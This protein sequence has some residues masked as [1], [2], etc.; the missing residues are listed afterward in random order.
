[1]EEI[2]SPEIEKEIGKVMKKR[3]KGKTIRLRLRDIKPYPKNSKIHTEKQIIKLMNS[4]ITFGYKAKIQVD[5]N[6]VVLVGHGRLRAFYM[7][8]PS[9]MK[10]IEVKQYD[11]LTESEKIA[12]RIVDNKI[13]SDTGFD[14]EIL[15]EEFTLLEGSESLSDTGFEIKE[16][17]MIRESEEPGD[18][19]PR[20]EEINL[21]S[22]ESKLIHTCPKCKF[23]FGKK[24]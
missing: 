8:D 23:K 12:Y 3:K 7:I 16:I 11:D 14:V 6:N 2:E 10:E 1:M 15:K 4:I 24:K 5:E 22:I 20:N 21:S 13:P 19:V 9:G 18:H 17:E